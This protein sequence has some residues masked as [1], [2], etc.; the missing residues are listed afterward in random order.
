EYAWAGK[1]Y[2]QTIVRISAE[3]LTTTNIRLIRPNLLRYATE[4]SHIRARYMKYM[5]S[6]WGYRPSF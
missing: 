2:N 5:I 4:T 1:W 3:L 6:F